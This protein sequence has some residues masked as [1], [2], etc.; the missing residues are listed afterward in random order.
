MKAQPTEVVKA[1]LVCNKYKPDATSLN[2]HQPPISTNSGNLSE[3]FHFFGFFFFPSL[4]FLLPMGFSFR[5]L[6]F[7][8][9]NI[10]NKKKKTEGITG[11]VAS[12][13]E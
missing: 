13:E 10:S 5:P 6:K 1:R 9:D 7:E 11:C 3:L 4:V 12:T 2:F 8:L